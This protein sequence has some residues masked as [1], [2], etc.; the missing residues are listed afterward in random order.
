VIVSAAAVF[1]V[2]VA[3]YLV[4][5][6]VSVG[7]AQAVLQW[8]GR[9]WAATYGSLGYLIGGRPV[10]LL[11]PLLPW[12]M[13]VKT[14]EMLTDASSPAR[15]PG[16]IV[17]A[18]G[19]ASPLAALQAALMF[20]VLPLTLHRYPGWPFFLALVAAYVNYAAIL[21]ILWVRRSRAG[22]GLGTIASLGVYGLV[23][24]PLSVNALR[25]A[26]LAAPMERSALEA[27]GMLPAPARAA[28]REA[29]SAHIA[30]WQLEF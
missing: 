25:K 14:R 18:L 15:R 23:C 7:R 6:L 12:R 30:E 24:L 20:V 29:L 1:W 22:L 3:I 17:R 27:I 26:S 28:S 4:D 5:C 10:M 9:R 2:G 8:T 21:T 19:P 11:N 13:T 16:A